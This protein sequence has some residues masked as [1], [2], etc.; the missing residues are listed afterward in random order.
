M[1][2]FHQSSGISLL[3][4]PVVDAIFPGI[5]L[6]FSGFGSNNG[7]PDQ[8]IPIELPAKQ[9]KRQGINRQRTP[10]AGADDRAAAG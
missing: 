9:G 2:H 7:N 6:L 5:Y 3:Y 10:V 8:R 4:S 1:R